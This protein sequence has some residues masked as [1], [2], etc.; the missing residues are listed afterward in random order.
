MSA[1]P[2][3]KKVFQSSLHARSKKI[4]ALVPAERAPSETGDSSCAEN[5]PHSFSNPP[6]VFSS[7]APSIASSLERLN[8]ADSPDENSSETSFELNND[9]PTPLTPIIE[10]VFP[11]QSQEP[12]FASL[13]SISSLPSLPTPVHRKRRLREPS[14]VTKKRPKQIQ[15]FSLSYKWKQSTFL[16]RAQI[17]DT[18]VV[19]DPPVVR[20]PLDY[21]LT[22]FS[23]DVIANVVQETNA[24]SVLKTGRSINLT[25]HEFRD[26][27]AIL[28]LMGIVSL[29][30]YLDYWSKKYRYDKIASV[31]SLKRYEAIRQNLHFADNNFES[32]DRYYKVRSLLEG[33]RQNCLAQESVTGEHTFSIDEMMVPYKG[34]KAGKRRQYMKDKPVK[35]G[36]KIYV[37]AGTSGMIY[38]FLPYGGDDTFRYHKFTDEERTLG[39][40]TQVVLGLCQTIKKKPAMV[41]FDNFFTSPELVYLLR[42]N[43]GIFSVGTIRSNRLRGAEE[44]LSSEKALKKKPRG[45]FSQTVCHKNKLSV[46]RWHD[47]KAATLISS[48]TDAEPVSRIKRYCKNAKRKVDVDYPNIVKE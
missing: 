46:V 38:D 18:A 35:W 1:K 25:E 10:Q 37:R 21:F 8:I 47:N 31:M 30:S 20:S 4:L 12:N 39:F 40:G 36:F 27:L 41:C 7:P 28:I 3:T 14:V 48:Y 17:E 26:F 45:S 9:F 23:E 43:Y 33:I 34:R 32:S 42:E 22:F 15:K 44:K 6:S 13:P 19:E 16:H 5:E 2:R 24:Y 29:P 11:N